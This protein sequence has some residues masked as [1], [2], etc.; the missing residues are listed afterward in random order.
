MMI[1]IGEKQVAEA[2]VSREMTAKEMGSGS[3]L[4]LATPCMAALMENAACKC[5]APYLDAGSST[6]G[7]ELTISHDSATP[8]GMDV[9]AEATVTAF[10]GRKITFTVEAFDEK[11]SIGS[12]THTRFVIREESFLQKTYDKL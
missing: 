10:E 4:V 12:G 3:L 5:V 8:V 7:T 6:V 1:P 2:T 11:G 9:R